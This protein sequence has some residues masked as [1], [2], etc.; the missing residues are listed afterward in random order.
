MRYRSWAAATALMMG[1]LFTSSLAFADGPPTRLRG[2][3]ASVDGDTI[4]VKT[5]AGATA[6]AK[7][8]GTT[9]FAAVT[10]AEIGAIA[11]DS[12]VGV[13]AVPGTGATLKAVEVTVF[14][15]VMR[16]AGDGHYPWDLG[17]DSSMTNGAV[18]NLTGTEGRTMTVQYKGGSADIFVPADVPIVNIMP[19]DR[20]ALKAGAHVVVFAP[21]VASGPYTAGV[22]IV[23][24]DGAVPPM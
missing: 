24:L 8:V 20:A 23:G 18:G 21:P 13:A 9:R 10:H 16:G 11:P 5:N 15:P 2:T 6:E 3:L 14:A 19:A 1:V 12:Y 4:T 22:V 17:P 7:L